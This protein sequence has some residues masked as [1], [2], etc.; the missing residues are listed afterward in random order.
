MGSLF[1]YSKNLNTFYDILI[2][3]I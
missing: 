1:T 2:S 3:S